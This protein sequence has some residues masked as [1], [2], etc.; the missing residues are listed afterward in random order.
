M[1]QSTIIIGQEL[2]ECKK[3]VGHGNW[4]NWLDSQFNST[5][6]ITMLVLPEGEEENFLADKATEGTPVE[7]MTVKILHTE[8]KNWKAEA[9]AAKKKVADLQNRI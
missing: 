5:Q 3:E 8:I 6:M 4:A 9:E 1:A 7:D 2:I